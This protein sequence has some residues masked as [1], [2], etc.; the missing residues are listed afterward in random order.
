M[1]MNRCCY[2]IDVG[3]TFN[4]GRHSGQLLCDVIADDPTY[5][6]WCVANIR[7]LGMSSEC[8]KQIK[9]LF[10]DYPICEDVVCNYYHCL[11]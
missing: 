9:M 11:E 6:L 2:F 5:L 8:Y 1:S 10:P 4:F 3:S 7:N